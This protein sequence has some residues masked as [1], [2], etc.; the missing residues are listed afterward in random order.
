E[1]AALGADLAR[2]G[3]R[4]FAPD[5][6]VLHRW[7]PASYR[8]HLRGEWRVQGFPGLTHVSTEAADA[9]WHG[10]FLHRRTAEVDVGLAGVAIA[11][12]TG[13]HSAALC[14]APWIYRR[15][16]EVHRR[17]LQPAPT[18][19]LQLLVADLVRT[20]ALVRGSVRARRVVL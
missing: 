20:A 11:L 9:L 8:D 15:A 3:G 18:R 17:G 4:A 13:R 7:I 10:V 1:D 12:I 6:V 14:A 2:A 16:R 19:T 5:A